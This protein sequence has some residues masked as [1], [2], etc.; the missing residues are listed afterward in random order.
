MS[1]GFNRVIV[2]GHL[3]KA[4]ESKILPSGDYVTNL[5]VATNEIWKDKSGEKQERTEWHKIRMFGKIA[6]VAEKY[7]KK[8]SMVLIEGSLRTSKWKDSDGNDRYSTEI[9]ASGLQMLDSKGSDNDEYQT[10]KVLNKNE[11]DEQIE[12]DDEVPF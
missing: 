4:P 5:S 8:G 3:G 7:L 1:K 11:Q 2:V 6:E 9:I 10:Q 12:E